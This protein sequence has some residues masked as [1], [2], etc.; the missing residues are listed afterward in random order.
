[1][2]IPDQYAKAIAEF[3]PVLQ[4]LIKAE[5]AAGNSIVEIGHG[6]PA[7]MNG[8]RLM[9]A[10]PLLSRPRASDAQLQFYERNCSSHSGQI[11]D[12]ARTFYV[13]EPPLPP[14][15]EADMD[16]IRA[17][18]KARERAS[19]NERWDTTYR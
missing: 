14:P 16:A 19:D 8:T 7:P 9:L 1:M 6:D 3:P 15:P 17:E 11:T 12:A 2:T 13:V 5:L 4:D 10:K 18:M